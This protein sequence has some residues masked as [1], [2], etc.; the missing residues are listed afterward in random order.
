MMA[1]VN[2]A[3]AVLSDPE[4]RAEYDRSR[5]EQSGTLASGPQ[6]GPSTSSAS[7]AS[8]SRT[9]APR[10][11]SGYFSLGFTKSQVAD[12]HGPPHN[13][14]IDRAIREEV[15]HYG[16]DDTI[17]F[18]LDTGRV[19]G[20]S[21]IR[22]NLQIRL[23]PGPNVTTLDF[24]ASGSHRDQVALLQGTPSVIIAH[25]ELNRELWLYRG[26]SELNSV[27]FDFSTGRVTDWENNDGSLKTRRS[28]GSPTSNAS[29]Q[30]TSTSRSSRT[31]GTGNWTIIRG[32]GVTALRTVDPVNPDYSLTVM[33]GESGV[34]IVVHWNTRI[35]HADSVTVSYRIDNGPIW[36]Q[37]WYV[38]SS[39]DA[40]IAPPQEI[41]ETIRELF[42]AK[43]FLVMVESPAENSIMALFET[44][45]FREA[46]TPLLDEWSRRRN[47]PSSNS[48]P[49]TG[50]PPSS[51]SY[52]S[53]QPTGNSRPSYSRPSTPSP[54]NRYESEDTGDGGCGVIAG[55][56]IATIV[57]TG[58]V[59]LIGGLCV[60]ALG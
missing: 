31:S 34:T 35:S 51:S 45:G 11:P 57:A 44:R 26:T 56:L 8:H 60:L 53:G 13:V 36:Q 23:I 30:R 40:S 16:S 32:D 14:S 12:I 4:K 38:S 9:N 17:E 1:A 55:S 25:Q 41:D 33:L 39:R 15:W 49:G 37:M 28:A 46:I 42:D 27:E 3:Y 48:R 5:A 52:S 29:N 7:Q 43:T 19:Q 24:F 10:N 50:R 47:P 21:N 54:D 18:D 58:L 59:A 2:R 20:W 6:T 22:G